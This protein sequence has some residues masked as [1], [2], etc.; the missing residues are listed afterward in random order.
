MCGFCGDDNTKLWKRGF[1]GAGDKKNTERGPLAICRLMIAP[2]PS[3]LLKK[4][5]IKISKNTSFF[6]TKKVYI[7]LQIKKKGQAT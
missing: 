1:P 6:L 7:M 3:K 2:L 4:V 5:I